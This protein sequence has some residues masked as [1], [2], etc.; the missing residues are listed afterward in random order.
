MRRYKTICACLPLLA[1]LAMIGAC[2]K[3]SELATG[4][5]TDYVGNWSGTV[6]GVE[7]VVDIYAD[8]TAQYEGETLTWERDGFDQIKLT[9]RDGREAHMTPFGAGTDFAHFEDSDGET[10][11][12]AKRQEMDDWP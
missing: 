4:E 11:P 2:N 5:E 8:G 10:F 9:Y 1:V 6:D 12:L 7:K 3:P